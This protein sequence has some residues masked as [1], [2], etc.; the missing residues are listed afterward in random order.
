MKSHM[1]TWTSHAVW[2][3]GDLL[4]IPGDVLPLEYC[5]MLREMLL[6]YRLLEDHGNLK[7][8]T[9]SQ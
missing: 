9:A 8:G 2:K 5:A 7:V 6:A 3:A 1:G 4:K